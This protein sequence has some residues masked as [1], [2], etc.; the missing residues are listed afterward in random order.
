MI[1]LR[2][3]LQTFTSLAH[4]E[5]GWA[6]SPNHSAHLEPTCLALLAL[7]LRREEFAQP[8]QRGLDFIRRNGT[9]AAVYRSLPDR[10]EAVWPTALVLF[11]QASL[12]Q[13][14]DEVQRTA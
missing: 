7:A 12:G 1:D 10:E 9:P 8:I 4:P 14:P 13:P 3:N 2:A 5:G 11:V 6:Y